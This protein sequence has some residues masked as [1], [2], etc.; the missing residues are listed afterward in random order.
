MHHLMNLWN[1][2]GAPRTSRCNWTYELLIC[3]GIIKGLLLALPR[4]NPV[5]SY[6]CEAKLGILSQ[7]L[8]VGR[9]YCL[10]ILASP[11]QQ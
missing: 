3:E 8:M 4:L 9:L 10:L 11:P 1:L 5:R 6:K 7:F 2:F